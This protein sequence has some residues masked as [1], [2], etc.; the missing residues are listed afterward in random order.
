MLAARDQH[1]CIYCHPGN[2]VPWKGSAT[3]E[4]QLAEGELEQGK[5]I[6]EQSECIS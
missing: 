2:L 3:T 5:S 6:G 4:D 1:K